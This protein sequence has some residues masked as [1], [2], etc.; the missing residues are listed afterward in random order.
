MDKTVRWTMIIVT[1]II[2]ILVSSGCLGTPD[3]S[4]N[5]DYSSSNITSST[6]A[7]SETPIAEEIIFPKTLSF[8]AVLTVT[9]NG[10]LLMNYSYTAFLD[11]LKMNAQVNFTSV[12]RPGFPGLTGNW[13]SKKIVIENG[14]SVRMYLTPPAMWMPVP[15]NQTK[16]VMN[17]VFYSNPYVVIFNS[18]SKDLGCSQ[19]SVNI[20]LSPEVSALL[21]AQF[22]GVDNA[23]HVPLEGVV[24]V[25]DSVI[26]SA[27]FAGVF[28]DKTYNFSLEVKG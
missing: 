15:E 5:H 10:S 19:C 9:E 22:V 3:A 4:F 18:T 17:S 23:P 28:G 20:T 8:D 25:D 21:L 24:M 13:H 1:F 26:V 2:G 12:Y 27:E 16:E 6:H 14:S 7:K 11:Y